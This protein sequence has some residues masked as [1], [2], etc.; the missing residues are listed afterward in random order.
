MNIRVI[1]VGVLLA[2]VA[3]QGVARRRSV[4]QPGYPPTI[5]SIAPETGSIRGGTLLTIRGSNFHAGSRVWI[6]GRLIVDAA[7]E[8][9]SQ[10]TLTTTPRD[11]GYGL[12]SVANAYGRATTEFL[13]VPP[14]FDELGSG[15]ITT[16]AGIG[17]YLGEG[18]DARDVP[19]EMADFAITPDRTAYLAEGR[20]AVIRRVTREGQIER[21]AGVGPDRVDQG[22]P[23]GDGGPALE[24]ALSLPTDVE[25][26]PDGALYVVDS[27][28]QRI[29]RIDARTGI[30]NTVAGSGP[31]ACI[32][33][34]EF[35]GDGGPATAARLNSPS[36]VAFG[37]DGD[38][39]ILDVLNARVRRVSK[40]IITTVAGNG[41]RGFSGDGGPAVNAQL[42]VGANVDY[43]AMKVDS[44]SN[45]YIA[46][47]GNRRVRR[48]DA[49]S[50]I[51]DT[52]LGGGNEIEDGVEARN[53]RLAELFG[54]ALDAEG[55]LYF[56]DYA[57]I[58]RLDSDGR[59]RTMIGT[60]EIGFSKDGTPV[61]TAQL[62]NPL[63]MHV[64]PGGDLYY[65]EFNGKLL[66]RLTPS[67]GAVVT[68]I[69]GIAPRAVG[70]DGPAIAALLDNDMHQAA[71]DVN[72]GIV[73]GGSGRVRRLEN[74][75]T[76]RTIAGGDLVPLVP[77][78]AP[79]P[80][81]AGGVPAFGIATDR[82]GNI[83]VSDRE[84]GRISPDGI[85]IPLTM[86]DPG[87]AGD[88]GPAS[89]AY[90][91]GAWALAVD[92]RDN[93]FIADTLNH[94][95]RRIDAATG[96]ISTIAGT[97]PPHPPD[98]LVP[99]PSSGDGGPATAAEMNLPLWIAI[100]AADRI[101]V[102]ETDR[103]R[104][105][106]SD[107]IIRTVVSSC[108]GALGTSRRGEVFVWCN[109]DIRRIDGVEQWT[110]ITRIDGILHSGDGLPAPE[111][112]IG[113][114][115]GFTVDDAGNLFLVD[116]G[117]R[118]LRGIKAP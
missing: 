23:L 59:V 14:R 16:L 109:G 95:I 33:C 17:N 28:N 21:I 11:N 115:G 102:A 94:R 4:R 3:G 108:F 103:V 31:I 112:G 25:V 18:R 118:R 88:G 80:A 63:R 76:L 9:N 60:F 46:D 70:E 65:M 27:Y 99:N 72:G 44:A 71:M 26:G 36:Q 107:G 37:G 52:V 68:T 117:T 101:Y 66:R 90:V 22:A 93:L 67:A 57:R 97:A 8:S 15:E 1:A 114:V 61:S 45:I 77:P 87:F 41:T 43:G 73:F 84:V 62:T 58:R 7:I 79:R 48:V 10:I 24:A 39:Y 91:D 75:G 12:V 38:M 35:S 20:N 30:I 53:V 69:A 51:I 64:Q 85:Y 86:A 2:S 116:A 78:G 42:D 56:S 32:L 74:D 82:H 96:I 13:Y 89:A 81:L 50:G 54:I 6:D 98:V 49:A 105:I 104:R 29:R 34:G 111:A 5:T 100:D 40:G 83:F 92:S 19:V 113:F 106:D 47:H 55:R 110:V